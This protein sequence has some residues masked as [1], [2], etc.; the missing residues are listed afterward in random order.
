MFGWKSINTYPGG[1]AYAGKVRI[2]EEE[3]QQFAAINA[4]DNAAQR[5]RNH[6]LN[7]DINVMIYA[8]GLGGAGEAE[9][10]LLRRISNDPDSSIYDSSALEGM[11]VYAPTAAD[12]N[13]AFVKIASEILRIAQ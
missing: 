8:V 13:M 4:V 1:H 12:L 3:N 10:D 6:A 2:D 5:I 7:A 9:H 11:Y